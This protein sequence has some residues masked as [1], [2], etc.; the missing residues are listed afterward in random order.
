[1]KQERT[2]VPVDA[3]LLRKWPLPYLQDGGG[4]E[5]RGRVLVVGGCEQVP[6]AARLAGE[7]ALRAGAGKLQIATVEMAAVPLAIAVPE[8]KVLGLPSDP[9]GHIRRASAALQRDC[10]HADAVLVG[11]GMD[12]S[13]LT[14]KLVECLL[15]HAETTL[16]ADAGA[17]CAFPR[18]RHWHA[19]P[20]LTPHAG[21][22][23][24]LTGITAENVA[25]DAERIALEFA[26]RARA[27][28]VLK[29]AVTHIATP[30][31][32][33][34]SHHGGSV[35]LGTS[36]SGDVLAGLIA[37]LVARGAPADQA[38]VWGV[39]LHGRAGESLE[40]E[41]GPLGFLAREISAQVPRLLQTL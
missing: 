36:G 10:A 6:G 5:E 32:Q 15:R 4:K 16:I 8:A 17:L 40:A 34:W 33:L 2:G 13:A 41:Y 7:A 11:P 14:S 28:V 9:R 20:I 27:L 31:G 26:A 1:M 3:A 29:G 24:A 25:D 22:M 37:G 21:E 19:P 23:A 38:A 30:D 35:G 12:H 18:A 39:Y